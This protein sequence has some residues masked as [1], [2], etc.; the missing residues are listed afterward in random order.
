VAGL[1]SPRF[2]LLRRLPVVIPNGMNL[3]VFRRA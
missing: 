1:P 3:Y 2:S